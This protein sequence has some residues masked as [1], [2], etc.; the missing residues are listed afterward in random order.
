MDNILNRFF[1]LKEKFS[2]TVDFFKKENINFYKEYSIL[3]KC[4]STY[5]LYKEIIVN[6]NEIKNLVDSSDDDIK[7]LAL[8]ELTILKEKKKKYEDIINKEYFSDKESNINSIYL[9]IRSATG[10]NESAIFAEDLFKM[11]INYIESLDYIYSILSF[12]IGNIGGYKDVIIKIVGNGVFDKFKYESG[13]HRVQRVPKTDSHDRIHTSTCSVAILPEIKFIDKIKIDSNDIRID[14]FRS[15]GAGGQH[16]N[17][18]DSAVRI[19]HIPT[20]IVAECQNERSQHKNKQM[21]F[22]LLASRLVDR[23]RNIQKNKIDSD[24]KKIVGSGFRSEKIRTYNYT[25]NRVTDHRLNLTIY[26]LS[27]ILEGRLDLLVEK[28][29]GN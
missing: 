23:E 11:Y 27:D 13:I 26:R 3:E 7:I 14:T 10:G 1:Y 28:F 17:V 4:V 9:E 21:A 19:T 24:R 25:E 16:V 2:N 18:T 12:S 6:I 29:Y 22:T 5:L 8:E 15:S 20:G